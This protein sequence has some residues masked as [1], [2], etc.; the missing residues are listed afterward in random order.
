MK[1][2]VLSIF[3]KEYKALIADDIMRVLVKSRA[4][5]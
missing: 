2:G 1:T 5:S 4:G 3:V